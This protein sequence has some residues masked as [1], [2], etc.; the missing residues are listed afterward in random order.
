MKAAEAARK[1]VEY[2]IYYSN[3]KA[4]NGVLLPHTL[5]RSIDGKAAEETTFEEI[6]VNPKIDKQKFAVSK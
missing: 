2:R 4:V 3:F 5:Q 6:K 1:T